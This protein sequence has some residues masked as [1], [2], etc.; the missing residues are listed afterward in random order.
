MVE[1]YEYHNAKTVAGMKARVYPIRDSNLNAFHAKGPLAKYSPVVSRLDGGFKIGIETHDYANKGGL[2]ETVRRIVDTGFITV[3]TSGDRKTVQYYAGLLYDHFEVEWIGQTGWFEV[4]EERSSTGRTRKQAKEV[5]DRS[6]WTV[7]AGCKCF[8]CEY[9]RTIGGPGI[10]EWQGGPK[11]TAPPSSIESPPER[12]DKAERVADLIGKIDDAAFSIS[13][14]LDCAEENAKDT[15]E[16]IEATKNTLSF[17]FDRI[18]EV[19][20]EL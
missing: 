8:E 11:S 9:T 19:K 6:G 2:Q 12:K 7:M 18:K 14:D 4:D 13:L 3:L 5:V 16:E 10:R 20:R 1:K 15:R 17:L